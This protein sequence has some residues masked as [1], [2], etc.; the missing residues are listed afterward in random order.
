MHFNAA[1]SGEKGGGKGWRVGKRT[2]GEGEGEEE[3][4]EEETPGTGG[5]W[6]SV[7]HVQTRLG[8]FLAMRDGMG[9]ECIGVIFLLAFRLPP[10]AKK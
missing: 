5:S 2:T 10:H 7:L 6:P 1:C 8:N 4:E 3:E 9:R